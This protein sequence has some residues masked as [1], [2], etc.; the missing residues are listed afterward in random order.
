ME[1]TKGSVLWVEAGR[2]FNVVGGYPFR[3]PTFPADVD[4]AITT[5]GLDTDDFI[6]GLSVPH[7]ITRHK[8]RSCVHRPLLPI[9]PPR[10]W[11]L[12]RVLG[13]HGVMK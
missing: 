7:R 3:A 2:P 4:T 5:D 10:A 6:M 8:L 1:P 11:G 12:M 13:V 9:P